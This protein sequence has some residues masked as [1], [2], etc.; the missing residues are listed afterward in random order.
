MAS[1]ALPTCP[2]T[3]AAVGV[4]Y[5]LRPDSETA[6]HT[7]DPAE[8]VHDGDGDG[9]GDGGRAVDGLGGANGA[10]GAFDEREAGLATGCDAA[11][12][13]AFD[14]AVLTTEP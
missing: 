10:P 1:T 3:V 4:P 13:T 8:I 12:D 11:S 6:A 2:W 9:D 7:V 5:W 14:V